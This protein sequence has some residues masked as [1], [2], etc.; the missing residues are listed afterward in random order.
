MYKTQTN[1]MWTD[2]KTRVHP[3]LQP[4][5]LFSGFFGR[6]SIPNLLLDR[7]LAPWIG[8]V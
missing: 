4:C 8:S 6:R 5:L 7:L 3:M 2:L 1:P